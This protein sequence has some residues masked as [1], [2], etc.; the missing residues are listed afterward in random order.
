MSA[1]S[2]THK[3]ATLYGNITTG[4]TTSSYRNIVDFGVSPVGTPF[5]LHYLYTRIN[6]TR[7][8][9]NTTNRVISRQRGQGNY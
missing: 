8:R 5:T 2:V 1:L 4:N 3:K 7:W 9:S 6:S